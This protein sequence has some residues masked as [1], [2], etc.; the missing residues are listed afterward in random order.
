[1]SITSPVSEARGWKVRMH[2][3]LDAYPPE[4]HMFWKNDKPWPMARVPGVRVYPS[5]VMMVP[6]SAW[7]VVEKF[8]TQHNQPYDRVPFGPSPGLYAGEL[9]EALTAFVRDRFKDYQHEAFRFACG[10]DGAALHHSPGCL[11]GDTQITVNRGGGS[12]RMRLDELVRKFNGGETSGRVWDLS[13]PTLVQ[14]VDEA[15]TLQLNRLV[16]AVSSGLKQTLLVR[17]GA[18]KRIRATADHGFLS[19]REDG[20]G[21]AWRRLEEL[22]VGDQLAAVPH[23]RA[24]GEREPKSY[25]RYVSH[26]DRH[27]FAVRKLYAGGTR[28]AAEVAEHRLVV[29]ADMNGVSLAEL[30]GR[31]VLGEVDGLK[32][33][34]ALAVVHHK[35]RN[36]LDNRRSNLVVTNSA[37]HATEH[38]REGAWRHVLPRITWTTLQ[39]VEPGA[40]EPTYDLSVQ[41]PLDNYVANR[42]VVH[43]S[44]KTWTAFAWALADRGSDSLFVTTAAARKHIYAQA[45]QHTTTDPIVLVGESPETIE[46]GHGIY[47]TTYTTLP[48]WLSFL[49]KLKPRAVVYDEVHG[50]QGSSSWKRYQMSYD[51]SGEGRITKRNNVSAA[52]LSLSQMAD[53]RLELTATPIRNV[54][55]DLWAQLDLIEPGRW[56]S[57]YPP[58]LDKDTKVPGGYAAAYCLGSEGAF[59]GFDTKG[60]SNQDELASRLEVVRHLVPYSISHANLPAKRREVVRL[61]LAEQNTC[62]DW[63]VKELRKLMSKRSASAFRECKLAEAA[64]RKRVWVAKRAVEYL[65]AGKKVVLFTGRRRDVDVLWDTVMRMLEVAGGKED[66][67]MV[68][69]RRDARGRAEEVETSIMK[70]NAGPDIR[71]WGAHGG[72]SDDTRYDIACAHLRTDGPACLVATLDSMG[73]SIDLQRTDWIC[74]AMLPEKPSRVIQGEGRGNRQGQDRELLCTYPVALKSYDEVVASALLDKLP[75]VECVAGDTQVA[76]L[77]PSLQGTDNP[78]KVFDDMYARIAGEMMEEERRRLVDV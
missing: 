30:V 65:M 6:D 16:S 36:T 8:L 26:M 50:E 42:L 49:R 58:Y 43:N 3:P 24:S 55:R 44:G 13:I 48:S 78:D 39:G 18:G 69:V 38:A 31:V 10:R 4:A 67:E 72:D 35:N 61:Q 1:M 75:A 9:P 2:L 53:R 23:R 22:R 76:S 25:Y 52:C 32:F 34:D 27:P 62:G 59:G 77:I 17:C 7:P 12:K 73:E 54:V 51:R 60:A 29:E 28:W 5:G 71:T 66:L 11:S 56:G 57:F 33:L 74:F 63:V 15:G 14:S 47:I 64:S 37:E 70:F 40:E 19:R 45:R 20:S 46:R 68:E 21:Q 41:A